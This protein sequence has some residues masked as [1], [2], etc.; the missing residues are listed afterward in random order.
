M[1]MEIWREMDLDGNVD[2]EE[3]RYSY[4]MH[5]GPQSSEEKPTLTIRKVYSKLAHSTRALFKIKWA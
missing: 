1:E 5:S 3:D 4:G 2:W